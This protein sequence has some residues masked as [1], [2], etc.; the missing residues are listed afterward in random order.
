MSLAFLCL[1]RPAAASDIG[2][3]MDG[4]FGFDF[5]LQSSTLTFL[6]G[7]YFAEGITD[8]TENPGIPAGQ[9]Y[10]EQGS[11]SA[12]LFPGPWGLLFLGTAYVEATGA[13]TLLAHTAGNVSGVLSGDGP[14]CVGYGGTYYPDGIPLIVTWGL[15]G[16]NAATSGAAVFS[17]SAS[18]QF[19]SFQQFWVHDD[20]STHVVQAHLCSGTPNL[21]ISGGFS[22]S[23]VRGGYFDFLHTFSTH[24]L[25]PQGVTFT[26]DTG[27]IVTAPP[28]AEPVPEP[29][30][31]L[32]LGTGIASLGARRWRHRKH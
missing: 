16:T 30:S 14:G 17:G 13:G 26:A 32:L 9:P 10:L 28:L 11:V 4:L 31:L 19:F 15:Y 23:G 29:T 1:A 24:I 21:L 27:Q 20:P 7:G 25:L 8:G 18:Y 5:G 22:V 2:I 12:E 3:G 6:S